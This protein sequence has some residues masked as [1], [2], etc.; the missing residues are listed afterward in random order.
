[1]RLK[2][3]VSS[4]AKRNYMFKMRI[5][6]SIGVLGLQQLI[7]TSRIRFP[8]CWSN[9]PSQ[10]INC[11]VGLKSEDYWPIRETLITPGFFES[12]VSVWV[13]IMALYRRGFDIGLGLLMVI[14]KDIE[15]SIQKWIWFLIC[16]RVCRS[17]FIQLQNQNPQSTLALKDWTRQ[18]FKL[19]CSNFRSNC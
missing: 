14:L 5:I 17:V 18:L 13:W 10:T 15:S 16:K 12:D 8:Y 2:V 9:L 3:C 4:S 7:N 6:T 19:T 11:K 1:M